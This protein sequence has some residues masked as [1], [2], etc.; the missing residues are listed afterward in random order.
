MFEK[1]PNLA[2]FGHVRFQCDTHVHALPISI[3]NGR[4]CCLQPAAAVSDPSME[5]AAQVADT[6]IVLGP[7]RADYTGKVPELCHTRLPTLN[8]T[9]AIVVHVAAVAVICGVNKAYV[10]CPAGSVG[11]SE[12]IVVC[13]KDNNITKLWCC[14]HGRMMLPASR[15]V[16]PH[17]KVK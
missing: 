8:I 6:F 12:L 11:N 10:S 5:V 3:L 15:E 4:P 13:V 2:G 9:Q 1:V 17:R 14:P 16:I 7:V